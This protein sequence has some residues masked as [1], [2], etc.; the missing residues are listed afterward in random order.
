MYWNK[1]TLVLLVLALLVDAN[2][3]LPS[4]L[5]QDETPLKLTIRTRH[6]KVC[7]HGYIEIEA[8]LINLGNESLTV[9]PRA[10]WYMVSYS[11]VPANEQEGGGSFTT[12][13]DPGPGDD[14]SAYLVL[15]PGESIKR[16]IAL[17]LKD[18][19]FQTTGHYSLR[20]T[21]GQFRRGEANGAKRY[22]GTVG[23]NKIKF[24]I[25]LCKAES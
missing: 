6:S 14:Q 22:F 2:A 23:S 21:Y 18:E 4:P 8:H 15:A 16:T 25:I 11:Q 10:L 24:E 1:M 20:V 7:S 12:I 17:P 3:V 5:T 13:G 19:F 9:A